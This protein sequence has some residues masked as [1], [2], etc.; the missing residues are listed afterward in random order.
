MRALEIMS[1]GAGHQKLTM[2]NWGQSLKLI[3]LQLHEKL[4]KNPTFTIPWSF[5]IWS[6]LERWKSLI[7]GC[8]MSWL[9]RK[10]KK[11]RFEVLSSLILCNNK[12]FL[13][14]T[15]MCDKKWILH[16]NQWW[17]VQWLDQEEA[18]KHFPKP[19]LHQKR[20][21]SLV[22]CCP[23]DPLQFSESQWNHYIW[24]VCSADQW[25][26]LKM[27]MTA[28]GI[29]QQKGPSFCLQHSTTHH[30]TKASLSITFTRVCCHFSH[31][32]LF[33]TLWA[34]AC[35]VPLSLGFSR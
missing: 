6:K 22:V 14:Q 8:L 29:G 11:G 35:Q 1:K 3:L 33:V 21:W 16:D 34:I 20:S 4:P 24:E 5:S 2:T 28:A 7:S 25:G 27:A 18:P 23:S 12:P 10:K 30:T 15:V 17:P 31:V 13:D 9:K 32:W 19:N 26:A